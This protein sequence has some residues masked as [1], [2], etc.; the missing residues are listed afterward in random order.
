MFLTLYN[1]STIWILSTK[2][3]RYDHISVGLIT[4]NDQHDYREF[5]QYFMKKLSSFIV[6]LSRIWLANVTSNWRKH[7]RHKISEL[8]ATICRIALHNIGRN[9]ADSQTRNSAD[10]KKTKRVRSINFSFLVQISRRG[11]SQE[12]LFKNWFWSVFM[13]RRTECRTITVYKLIESISVS[14]FYIWLC[15][16]TLLLDILSGRIVW[17][18]RIWFKIQFKDNAMYIWRAISC[19]LITRYAKDIPWY[20]TVALY[21]Q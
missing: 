11:R 2:N 10:K 7:T 1:M 12:R 4:W 19:H 9:V 6:L 18:S 17:D 13:R 20:R 21:D 3:E 5:T 14:N 15:C 16:W 8:W